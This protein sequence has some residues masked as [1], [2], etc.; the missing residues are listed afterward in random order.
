M[1]KRYLLFFI[2]LTIKFYG[3][4]YNFNITYGLLC[5]TCWEGPTGPSYN[6]YSASNFR[7]T[8]TNN[9]TLIAKDTDNGY[10][11]YG[12]IIKNYPN[13]N[14]ANGNTIKVAINS[15]GMFH[16]EDG[17]G[18][19]CNTNTNTS[20][21]VDNLILDGSVGFSDSPCGLTSRIINFTPNLSIKNLDTANPT[22]ICAGFQLS[23]SAFSTND[24]GIFPAVA[25]HWQ[26][27][28][29]DSTWT[30]LPANIINNTPNPV[31]SIQQLLGANHDSYFNKKIYFRIGYAYRPFSTSLALTYLPCAPVAVKTDYKAPQCTGDNIQGID[32]Y[33]EEKLRQ[34]ET[35]SLIYLKNTD[36]KKTTP[37]FSNKVPITTLVYD[38]ASGLY[39]YSFTTLG[40]LEE[41]NNYNVEYQASM[42]SVPSGTLKALDTFTY[43]DPIKVEFNISNQITPSC[44]GG[45]DGAIE[46]EVK[47]G[48]KDYKFYV[49]GTLTTATYNAVN[50]RYYINGLTAKT[51]DIKVT[52]KFDCIDKTTK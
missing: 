3:Q 1:K 22:T 42:N 11:N 23:L 39:K 47:G 19:T 12:R 44:V 16:T 51:Y 6:S 28:L 27:S 34:N 52:D 41:G 37:L 30:D 26:Y 13:V 2:L 32:V 31:F 14:I 48:T 7:W 24:S 25:Y 40:K 35:L 38:T 15:T 10:V 8:I 21:T 5:N 20:K 46:I 17:T 36:P 18:Y 43:K 50:D 33:F 4:T 45:N 29:D 9:A 49:D